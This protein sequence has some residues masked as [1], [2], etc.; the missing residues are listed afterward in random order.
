[1]LLGDAKLD[2]LGNALAELKATQIAVPPLRRD[3]LVR[4]HAVH[5]QCR[6][7]DICDEGVHPTVT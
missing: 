5:F 1:M 6:R 3:A 2:C 7:P 4:G